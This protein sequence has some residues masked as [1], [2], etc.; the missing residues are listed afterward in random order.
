[1]NTYEKRDAAMTRA[2]QL[3]AEAQPLRQKIEAALEQKEPVRETR[4]RRLERLR[5]Q[6]EEA[7]HES[8][9]WQAEAVRQRENE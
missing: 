1:V 4:W 6:I 7:L 9:K 8:A 2:K 3:I 5:V